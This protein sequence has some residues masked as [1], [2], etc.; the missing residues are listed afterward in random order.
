MTGIWIVGATGRTGRA[1]AARLAGEHELVLVGRDADRLQAL[2]GPLGADVRVVGSVDAVPAAVTSAAPAVVVNLIGPYPVTG[3]R[4]ARACPPGTH[5]V[6]LANE[7]DGVRALLGTHDE[8][9]A[10][11]RTV[12]TGAGFGVL[13]TESVALTLCADRPAPAEI[14]VDAVPSVASEP[15]RVGEALAGSIVGSFPLGGLRYEGGRLV[16][17]T[18]GGDEEVLALPDG[19]SARTAGMPS[20]ELEAARRASGAPQVVAASA[21]APAGPLARAVLPGVVRL[22]RVSPLRRA[23]TAGLARLPLP[24][25]PPVRAASFARARVRDADGTV[26]VAWFRAG[27]AMDFTV[28][29]AAE[30]TGRL[31]RGEGEPGAYT[32]GAAFGPELAVAAGGH[33]EVVGSTVGP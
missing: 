32:P 7:L 3:P 19:S 28:G 18:L 31:A 33:L 22:M 24:A 8:A 30:V 17:A 29:V 6:D 23:A 26:R 20:G 25:R 1:I 12:V 16:P 10:A 9:V 27:D 11:D 21:L 14:R 15:G 5:Y 13:G 2:A 4:I